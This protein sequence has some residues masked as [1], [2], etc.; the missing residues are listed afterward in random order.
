V[1]GADARLLGQLLLSQASFGSDA[2]HSSTESMPLRRYRLGSLSWHPVILSNPVPLVTRKTFRSFRLMARPLLAVVSRTMKNRAWL[3]LALLLGGC[4]TA[5]IRTTN[6][7]PNQKL[8]RP[9]S[10]YVAPIDVAQGTW[11]AEGDDLVHLKQIVKTD[12][13]QDLVEQLQKI[14]PTSLSTGNETAGWL[15]VVT[16]VSVDPGSAVMR[17]LVAF[18]TGQAKLTT[19]VQIYN[20]S[21]SN[22]TPILTAKTESNSGSIGQDTTLPAE[23]PNDEGVRQ[24][25]AWLEAI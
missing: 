13:E 8:V 25:R 23:I 12:M 3:L 9:S 2:G 7:P 20:L 18:G 19:N 21:Q 15:V 17:Q 4:A 16:P 14:A 1:T 22:T 10:I 11:K 6:L 5:N 24:S